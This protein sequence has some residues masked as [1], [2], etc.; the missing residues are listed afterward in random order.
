MEAAEAA[1]AVEA[2]QASEA[3]EARAG[4]GGGCCIGIGPLRVC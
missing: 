3:A 1:E 2:A 4:C